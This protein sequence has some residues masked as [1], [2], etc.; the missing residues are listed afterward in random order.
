MNLKKALLACGL[1]LVLSIGI[2]ATQALGWE[3]PPPD[4][5]KIIGPAMWAVGVCD[6]TAAPYATLRVKKIKDC[7]VDTDPVKIIQLPSCPASEANIMYYRLDTGSVFGLPC[8]PII[9][10]VKNFKADGDLVSFDAQIQFVVPI[11][12]TGTECQ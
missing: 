2:T 9:T 8:E 3:P 10:K 12:Y 5:E 4:T 6:K 1:M 11:T 7:D